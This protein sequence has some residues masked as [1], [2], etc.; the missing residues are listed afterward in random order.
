L[1]RFTNFSKKG[2]ALGPDGKV[3]DA[4][5][6]ARARAFLTKATQQREFVKD[7]TYVVPYAWFELGELEAAEGNFE[8]AQGTV[9]WLIHVSIQ[10]DELESLTTHNFFTF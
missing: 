9:S 5:H 2:L 7:E 1:T 8:R 3:R 10:I 6:I 4:S